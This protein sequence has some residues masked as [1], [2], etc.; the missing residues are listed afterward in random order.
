MKCRLCG[1]EVGE[2]RIGKG[3]LDLTVVSEALWSVDSY[4]SLKGS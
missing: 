1:G 3:Y 4:L 2:F